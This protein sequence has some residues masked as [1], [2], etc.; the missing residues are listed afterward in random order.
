MA[1]KTAEKPKVAKEK[2]TAKTPAP[3]KEPKPRAVKTEPKFP[4]SEIWAAGKEYASVAKSALK[5]FD[6]KITHLE[7]QVE[8]DPKA[9]RDHITPLKFER[10][11]VERITL[12]LEELEAG[13]KER[14]PREP[15]P[16]DETAKPKA[17]R[18]KAKKVEEP[19]EED[20]EEEDEDEEEDEE[21]L[22]LED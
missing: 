2:A 15:K 19:E 1:A 10:R 17:T 13:L 20:E 16:K 22:D 7:K 8:E 3:A 4:V 12:S 6:A 18:A 14:K 5:D 11:R 9:Y 21:D